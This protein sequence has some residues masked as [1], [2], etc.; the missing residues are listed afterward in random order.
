MS[1][2]EI[3]KQM[4]EQEHLDLFVDAYER[5]TGETLEV[6]RS[7]TPDFIGEDD[8]GRTVGVELTQ[9]R[10]TNDER[11][12]RRALGPEPH[13]AWWRLLELTQQKKELLTKGRWPEC[14]RKILVVMLIDATI[15]E[16]AA[17]TDTDRPEA[18]GFDEIWLADYSQVEAFRA[19][20][21]FA[22]AH[23]KLEGHF[24]TG[25]QGQKPYG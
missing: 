18:G 9:L 13:D 3:G 6:G 22:V 17:E 10:F 20:D 16:V 15:D 11:D 21:L 19:V 25:D 12:M 7:E 8:E 2:Q 23:P 14:Q 1:D 4:V 5:A 24:A